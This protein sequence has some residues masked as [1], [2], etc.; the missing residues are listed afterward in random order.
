MT[1]RPR[2]GILAAALCL[3][4]GSVGAGV[5]AGGAITAPNIGQEGTLDVLPGN[6]SQLVLS[7]DVASGIWSPVGSAPV[8][9]ASGGALSNLFNGCDYAFA[10]GGSQMFFATGGISWA[11]PAGPLASA[12]APVAEGA[13]LATAPGLGGAPT[14]A[15]FALRG[16]GTRDFWRYSI[17]SDSWAVLPETPAPVGDGGALAEFASNGAICNTSTFSVA[18]L[19]GSGT[20]DFWCYNIDHAAWEPGPSLPTPV[21]PGGA[22]AQL[23]RL[24]HIYALSGGGTNSFW[25]LEQ[26]G[27]WSPL[28]PTPGPV[29]AG[30][31]LVA[32]NY[33]T[34]SQRDVLYALQGGG[35]SAVWGYDVATNTWTQ[36]ASVP[37]GALNQPPDC[38]GAHASV[39]RL[40]PPTL[41]MR[42]VSIEGVSDPD[43]DPVSL[44]IDYV[45][46]D[47]PTLGRGQSGCTFCPDAEWAASVARL[48]AERDPT[49]NGR[50]Y[51]LGF[52]ATDGRNGYCNGSVVVCVPHDAAHGCVA[53]QRGY[54]SGDC[55]FPGLEEL[56]PARAPRH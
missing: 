45:L 3:V 38:S 39:A 4:A 43:G 27:V 17:G 26:A 28:A 49:G 19:R 56:Q 21:G 44:N 12:P 40:W 53:D 47:E 11:C 48:R 7:L 16:G 46:Q 33:G 18:A 41:A 8:P 1:G 31:S 42:T 37:E 51:R 15:V 9:V 20:G 30:G 24:G 29:D 22:L 32:I 23:Q 6:G 14:D 5:G 35:S 54:F 52:S 50:V 34:L 10:G 2:T 36:V 25:R 55:P 13:A